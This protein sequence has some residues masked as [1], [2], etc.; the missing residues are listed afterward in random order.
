MVGRTPD[1]GE[2]RDKYLRVRL[3]AVELSYLDQARDG[4]TRS[5]YVRALIHADLEEKGLIV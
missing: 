1:L 4:D 5:D 2:A 3:A